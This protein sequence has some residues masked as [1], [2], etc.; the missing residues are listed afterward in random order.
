[1]GRL[2]GQ[3]EEVLVDNAL[4][5]VQGPVNLGDL[6]ELAALKHRADQRLVDDGGWAAALCDNYFTF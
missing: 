6:R 2:L 1:M 3:I 4:H 5:P